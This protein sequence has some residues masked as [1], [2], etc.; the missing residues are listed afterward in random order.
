[1]KEEILEKFFSNRCSREELGEFAKWLQ[2]EGDTYS[3]RIL[4]RKYWDGLP[5]GMEIPELSDQGLLDRVHHL[6]NL[7]MNTV[8]QLSGKSS[9][10][11]REVSA[12]D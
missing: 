1:M 9:G 3:S 11:F 10:S 6:L 5:P 12:H 7:K 2:E 8:S 4:F